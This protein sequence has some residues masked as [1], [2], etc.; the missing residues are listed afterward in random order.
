VDKAIVL[1]IFEK[2]KLESWHEKK[3]GEINI[4]VGREFLG[5]KYEA[6]VLDKNAK[7]Q[8][9]IN[10]K[11]LDCVT[12]VENCS[13]LSSSIKQKQYDFNFYA[14]R[15]QNL[16]YRNGLI[17]DYSSRLHY[18]SDWLYENAKSQNIT[19]I[20]EKIA[21]RAFANEVFF[22]SKNADKYPLLN[23]AELIQNMKE[24]EKEIS[25]RIYFYV[26]EDKINEYSNLIPDGS[27]I[28]ITC[29]INGLDITHTGLA[30][31]VN[32]Q[33]HLLHASSSS[34][35]V[36]ISELNLQEMLNKNKIQTGIMVAELIK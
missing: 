23:S 24:K 27:I 28:G 21:N 4:L 17:E 8:L 5:T 9:V 36:E 18:F 29:N 16:R 3:L 12:F 1:K 19:Q 25:D 6:G 22:M 20:S 31:H 26:P 35:K 34:M 14:A 33:L 10:L 32:D 15:L 2:A 7:E 13:A 30:I 11:G